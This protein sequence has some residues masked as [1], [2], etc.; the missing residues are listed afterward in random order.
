MT[1]T[2]RAGFGPVRGAAAVPPA[3]MRGGRIP[4]RFRD[5]LDSEQITRPRGGLFRVSI[6]VGCA[7]P[8]VRAAS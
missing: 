7:D 8:L 1:S 3:E 2:P 6:G 4:S 5:A